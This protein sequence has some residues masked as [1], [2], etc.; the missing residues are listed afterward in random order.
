MNR[1]PS[2]PTQ[3]SEVCPYLKRNMMNLHICT[4]LFFKYFPFLHNS[5][6]SLPI[7]IYCHYMSYNMTATFIMESNFILLNLNYFSLLITYLFRNFHYRHFSF[8]NSQTSITSDNFV[9][10]DRK[11]NKISLNSSDLLNLESAMI[12]YDGCLAAYKQQ[13]TW[14]IAL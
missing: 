1:E 5:D 13:K 10:K 11:I 2:V 4:V 7:R 6:H 3:S 9:S 8:G 12:S 14:L